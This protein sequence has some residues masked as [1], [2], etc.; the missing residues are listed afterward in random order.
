M[1]ILMGITDSEQKHYYSLE[2]AIRHRVEIRHSPEKIIEMLPPP[3]IREL[4]IY[5]AIVLEASLVS[6]SPDLIAKIRERT[7]EEEVPFNTPIVVFFTHDDP[8]QTKELIEKVDGM[9]HFPS[10]SSDILVRVESLTSL[11][12]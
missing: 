12:R 5:D 6:Q 9:V 3:E 2:L 7:P 8:E 1:R 10:H 4:W 11:V